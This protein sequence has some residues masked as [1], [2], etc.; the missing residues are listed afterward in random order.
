MEE[1][2]KGRGFIVER[3]LKKLISPFFEM[4]EKR[5]WQSLG[6]HKAPGC[7]ALVK[8]N[9]LTWWKRKERQSMLE[10]NGYPSAGSRYTKLTI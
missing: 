1:S 8:K 4:L 6:E 10:G 9:F 7:A 3:G 5:G 2:L